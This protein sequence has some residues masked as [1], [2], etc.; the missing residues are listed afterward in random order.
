MKFHIIHGKNNSW[1]MHVIPKKD[2]ATGASA[3]YEYK[4]DVPGDLF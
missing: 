3:V 1:Q 2:E 4:M